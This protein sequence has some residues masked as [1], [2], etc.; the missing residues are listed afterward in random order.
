[1]TTLAD[2]G[3]GHYILAPLPGW[4]LA[5]V[6]HDAPVAAAARRLKDGTPRRGDQAAVGEWLASRPQYEI[7]MPGHAKPPSECYGQLKLWEAA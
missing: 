3:P 4:V 1:M 2:L 6:P 7:P 5:A